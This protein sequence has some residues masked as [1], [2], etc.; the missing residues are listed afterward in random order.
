MSWKT[1]LK[2]EAEYGYMLTESLYELVDES[3]LDWKPAAE[4]NWMTVGQLLKHL[5]SGCGAGF[6]GFVTGDWGMSMEDMKDMKPEDMLPP[7]GKLPTVASLA[8]A[9]EMLAEDKKLAFE[10]LD[11]VSEEDLDTKPAPAPW[12]KM[13]YILG[14]RLLQMTQHLNSHRHQLFYYLKLQGVNVNTSHLWGGM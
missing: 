1:L 7:A 13:D 10:I 6:K 12:D 2:K 14:H 9:K 4:N 11:G 8:E 5:G 3:N